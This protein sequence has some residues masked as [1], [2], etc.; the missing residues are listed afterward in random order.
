MKT[1]TIAQIK[2][3][4]A[5]Q[6]EDWANKPFVNKKDDYIKHARNQLRHQLLEELKI[7]EKKD[8]TKKSSL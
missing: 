4:L 2:K 7:K 3:L 1:Y 8:E 5:M 6:D